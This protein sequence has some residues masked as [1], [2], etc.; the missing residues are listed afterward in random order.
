[1]AFHK[2]VEE[3]K[4][5]REFKE[6]GLETTMISQLLEYGKTIDRLCKDVMASF[7][8]VEDGERVYQHLLGNAGYHGMAIKAPNYI[9]LISQEGENDLKNAG[10]M[11]EQML[12]EASRKGIGSCWV[13]IIHTNENLKKNIGIEEKGE[14]LALAALGYPKSNIFGTDTSVSDR[15]SIEKLVYF[16]QW[17]QPMSVEEL[18]QRGLE[19]VF[20][21]VRHAPSWGNRQPWKFILE[22][23]RLILTML[24]EDAYIEKESINN[25]H[26][27]DCGIMMLYIEKM[28]HNQGIRGYWHLDI[29]ELNKEKQKYGIPED[30]RIMGW[31]PL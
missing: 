20:F 7:H 18:Q 25:N 26:E 10:Y 16:K 14:I 24:K 13:D 28:M 6:K 3:R 2:L 9:V 12:L 21:Y 22:D 23:D 11:M 1:M 8:F 31:F 30:R 15:G 27:L 29:R 19:E 17:D 4:S 5:I